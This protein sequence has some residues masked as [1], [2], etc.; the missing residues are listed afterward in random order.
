[1]NTFYLIAG[2]IAL[3]ATVGHFLVGYKEFLKPVLDSNT[4]PI[5]QQVMRSLFHYMSIFQIFSTLTFLLA[6]FN[7][8]PF[9]TDGILLLAFIYAS[10][11]LVQI[12]VA[13]TSKIKGGL[14]KLF[15]WIFWILI[16]VS[17]LLG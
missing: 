11:G 15:Q 13:L 3:S 14:F 5:P 1:M 8:L 12:Y 7:K 2:L 17:A 6:A 4:G 10:F 9:H 16:A